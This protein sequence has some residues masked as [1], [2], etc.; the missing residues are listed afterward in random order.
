MD[1]ML[2][3]YPYNIY[4]KISEG[5]QIGYDFVGNC[6]IRIDDRVIECSAEN[7]AKKFAF[8]TLRNKHCLATNNKHNCIKSS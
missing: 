7:V 8:Y 5:V 6:Q 2:E 3:E 4:S 1:K